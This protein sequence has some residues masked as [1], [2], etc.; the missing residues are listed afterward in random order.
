MNNVFYPSFWAV[1]PA[2]GLG[3]RMD[4]NTPKQYLKIYNHTILEHS[5]QPILAHP[6][7]E[8]MMVSLNPNDIFWKSLRSSANPKIIR[9]SG[10]SERVDSVKNAL[11]YM[12]MI[13]VPDSVWVLVH[14]SARP[15]LSANDLDALISGAANDPVGA[16]LAA[17]MKNTLKM[18]TRLDRVLKTISRELVWEAYT[19]QMFQLGYLRRG[20]EKA[21]LSGVPITDESSAIEQLGLEPKLIEGRSDNIKI[22]KYEDLEWLRSSWKKRID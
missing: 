21:L 7:L 17:P 11:E 2:A 15:N 18:S 13:G 20:I 19:P 4:S 3:T 9:V 12:H 14:D 10:G 16:I 1:I 22:T 5:I 8:F 6:G